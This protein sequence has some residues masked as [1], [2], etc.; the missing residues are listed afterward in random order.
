M[1]GNFLLNQEGFSVKDEYIV[2]FFLFVEIG[3]RKRE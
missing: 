1:L 3:V 2:R